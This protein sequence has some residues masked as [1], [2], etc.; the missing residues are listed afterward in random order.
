VGDKVQDAE[1]RLDGKF[2]ETDAKIGATKF[3]LAEKINGSERRVH[4]KMDGVEKGMDKQFRWTNE[5]VNENKFEALKN[6]ERAQHRLTEVSYKLEKNMNEN[7]KDT[8]DKLCDAKYA[9]LK[10]KEALA[11]QASQNFAQAQLQSSKLRE[12][13]LQDSAA[14][15]AATQMGQRKA[16]E[17]LAKQAADYHF[18]QSKSAAVIAAQQQLQAFQNKAD[19]DAKLTEFRYESLRNKDEMARML[20]HCCCDLRL[21]IEKRSCE[22]NELIKSV[23]ATNVRDQLNKLTTENTLLKLSKHC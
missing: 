20:E 1:R 21:K 23:D 14:H 8:S 2:C 10:N 4:A 11:A 18:E 15:F 7:Q 13:V 17:S 19:S 5:K 22:T 6:H 12:K 9:A 16:K 3:D